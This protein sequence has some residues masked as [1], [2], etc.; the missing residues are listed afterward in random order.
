MNKL[1]EARDRLVAL[2]DAA[3]PGP[4]VLY[5]SP[6]GKTEIEYSQEI[7]PAYGVGTAWYPLAAAGDF[8]ASNA[9]FDKNTAHLIVTLR[10]TIDTQIALL[11]QE[12]EFLE[13]I[14]GA[15]NIPPHEKLWEFAEAILK[16]TES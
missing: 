4:W 11:N 12:I 7:E 5:E 8:A 9:S 15:K 2:R 1:I 14:L 6:S 16:G 3:N 10:N 13:N